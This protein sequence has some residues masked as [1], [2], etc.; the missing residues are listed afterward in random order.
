MTGRVHAPTVVPTVPLVVP[1]VP[2]ALLATITQIHVQ[3]HLV[4]LVLQVYLVKHLT[5]LI[6]LAVN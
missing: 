3:I 2:L 5:N 6:D 4:R 1:T